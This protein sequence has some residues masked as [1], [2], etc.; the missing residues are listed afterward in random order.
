MRTQTFDFPGEAGQLLSGRLD[1]PAAEPRGYALFAHCFTCTKSSVAA[2]RVS[3]ALAAAG[4]GVLR[5]DFT[6]LG[7]SGGTFA[8]SSFS[9]SMADIVAAAEAMAQAGRVISLLIGHSLGGAA[10]LATAGNLA[11]LKGVVTIG[12][13]FDVEHVLKLFGSKL[14]DLVA[15]G[16][17]TVSIGGR[18][19]VLRRSFV[20]DLE[21]HDQGARLARLRK[22]LLILHSPQDAIVGIENA[23]SIYQNARHPKSF[24][25]LDGADHLLARPEDADYVAAIV[26]AWASR[27]IRA[28]ESV[29]AEQAVQH[30]D[31]MES[32]ACGTD[33]SPARSGAPGEGTD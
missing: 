16:E 7:Q 25:A 21:A 20:D 18:P 31:H 8:A 17:A 26:S 5:F 19:F 6:G 12:A 14:E 24:V 30:G 28:K 33:G 3:R 10:V 23:A 1:L 11:S 13:P 22:P 29:P 32:A 2:V 15:A 27:Y 4:Y 9:G